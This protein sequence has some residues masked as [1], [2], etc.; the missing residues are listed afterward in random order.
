MAE[1][2][3]SGIGSLLEEDAAVYCRPAANDRND[4]RVN[5]L[6]SACDPAVLRAKEADLSTAARA[7]HN[8]PD[9]SATPPTR[10][11]CPPWGRGVSSPLSR[12][13]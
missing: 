13:S 2:G 1:F 3:W 4:K 10:Q 8:R 5:V 12:P 7:R 6:G 11:C 9:K